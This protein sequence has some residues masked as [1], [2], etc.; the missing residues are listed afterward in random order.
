MEKLLKEG[1]IADL[2]TKFL[3][4]TKRARRQREREVLSGHRTW[5]IQVCRYVRGTAFLRNV[6]QKI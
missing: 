4:S 6:S 1:M 2:Q 3:N 5:R